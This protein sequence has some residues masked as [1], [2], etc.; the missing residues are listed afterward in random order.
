MNIRA[1]Q[2]A[3][4]KMQR[5]MA[6]KQ[7]EFDATEF[8]YSSNGGAIEIK[9]TGALNITS[10]EI[11]EDILEDKEMAQDMILIAV[12]EAISQTSEKKD[13]VMSQGMPKGMGGMF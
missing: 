5:Q 3:A 13:K 1:M 11:D 7:E 2:Q 8:D 12:N 9:I 4:M 6:K 10:F